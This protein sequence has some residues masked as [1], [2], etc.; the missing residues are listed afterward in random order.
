MVTRWARCARHGPLGP[1]ALA[2]AVVRPVPPG[3]P[4]EE[5]GTNDTGRAVTETRTEQPGA[6]A[7]T[8][9]GLPV[10]RPRQL[11]TRRYPKARC[12]RPQSWIQIGTSDRD[13]DA[14]ADSASGLP[15]WTR[16]Q[17]PATGTVTCPLSLDPRRLPR[18]AV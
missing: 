10:R 14:D 8:H 13:S 17:K 4:A 12:C 1:A 3:G 5:L 16:L 18:S 9:T 11:A 6:Q 2:C 15:V 7:P